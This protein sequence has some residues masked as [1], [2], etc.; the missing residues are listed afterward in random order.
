MNTLYMFGKSEYTVSH[1][2]S[3][4]QSIENNTQT[5]VKFC[6]ISICFLHLFFVSFPFGEYYVKLCTIR[7]NTF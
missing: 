7:R 6:H 5:K 2:D 3:Q 4:I 1:M